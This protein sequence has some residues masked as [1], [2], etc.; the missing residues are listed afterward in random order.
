MHNRSLTNPVYPCAGRGGLWGSLRQNWTSRTPGTSRK[1]RSRR[2]A[3]N[4]RPC[5]E[6]RLAKEQIN[7][8]KKRTTE[9]TYTCMPERR[10]TQVPLHEHRPAALIHDNRLHE[11]IN[12]SIFAPCFTFSCLFQGTF[13]LPFLPF[14]LLITAANTENQWQGRRKIQ[15]AVTLTTIK[16]LFTGRARTA[17]CPRTRRPPWSHGEWTQAGD[18]TVSMF[19]WTLDETIT[20]SL[21]FE[22][23]LLGNHLNSTAETVLF[24]ALCLEKKKPLALV[25]SCIMHEVH[26]KG[27]I[28]HRSCRVKHE[29]ML[30]YIY[31]CI[32][33]DVH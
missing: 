23:P 31:I 6:S 14:G 20:S 32:F 28:M 12:R 11:I 17:R 30:V 24:Y 21:N 8:H 15:R 29:C 13:F 4:P 1:A 9:K 25:F 3:W 18:L 10:Q 22:I 7:K 5:R 27:I 2:P 33:N 16:W 26:L 19:L